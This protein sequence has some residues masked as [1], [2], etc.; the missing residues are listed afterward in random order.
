MTT[1]THPYLTPVARTT[2]LHRLIVTSTPFCLDA[3]TISWLDERL[4]KEL[5]PLKVAA[6]KRF[7]GGRVRLLST[8]AEGTFVFAHVA[9]EDGREG[10]LV[11]GIS[12]ERRDGGY[13]LRGEFTVDDCDSVID[14]AER[15]FDRSL[16]ASPR[17]SE[18]LQEV[19]AMV[20]TLTKSWAAALDGFSERS[21]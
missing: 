13:R 14:A 10:T 4:R 21:A 11:G 5:E 2:R 17:P 15:S 6:S 19:R 20:K 1:A 16:S 9:V 3:E 7:P 18:T 8:Q 12:F